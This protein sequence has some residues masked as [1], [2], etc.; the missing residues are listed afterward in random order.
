[1]DLWFWG[2]VLAVGAF[3]VWRAWRRRGRARQLML[4]CHRADLEFS[5]IDP[6]PDTLWLPF[7]WL[8]DGRWSRAENVV[9]NRAEGDGVRAFDLLIEQ[10]SPSQ[11]AATRTMRRYACAVVALPV[12]CPRLEIRPSD[13]VAQVSDAFT[14]SDIE[15]ELEAFNRRFRVRSED[16]RFAV[17]FCD[18]RMMRA[19]LGLPSGVAVAVNEDRMLLRAGALPAAEVLLLFEAARAMRRAVPDVVAGL[20]PPRPAKGRHEDRWLQGHWSAGPTGDDAEAA[21]SAGADHP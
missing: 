15:L 12:G 19:M 9:W 18:Q 4:L 20:Y 7:R 1:M 21:P 13:A 3:G 16:R 10:A 8:G 6:F 11:E 2:V 5:P 14:G 17:A